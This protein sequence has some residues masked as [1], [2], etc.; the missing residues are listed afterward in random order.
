[1]AAILPRF[2]GV[3]FITGAGGTGDYPQTPFRIAEPI[4]HTHTPS[5][6]GIGAAVAAAL[7]RSGC[8]K[9]AITDINRASLSRTH[10]A[11][12]R[13]NPKAHVTS[14]AGDISD[15][16]FVD[17]LMAEA[18]KTFRRVDYAVNC[19]GILGNDLRSTETPV[20]SF[21]T[22]TNVNYK[23]TWLTA[24]AALG[25]ML[26]QEPLAEHPGQR[27]AVVNIA[28]QLGIVARPGAG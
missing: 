13:I 21:D 26:K 14:N 11:L 28:S 22:I 19:A 12:M 5:F 16:S 4:F 25:Q 23:G 8:T 7:A 10:D 15:P 6:L 24:R 18:T 9:L 2:P 20:S 3:A 17:S 27:G 1:M